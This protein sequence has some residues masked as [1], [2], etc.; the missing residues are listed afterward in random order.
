VLVAE[1]GPPCGW[2]L[3]YIEALASEYHMSLPAIFRLSVTA[4]LALLEARLCRLHPSLDRVSYVERCIIAARNQCR[5]D[6][7][8]RFTLIPNTPL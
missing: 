1:A 8:S 5:R 7:L 6:L 4:G 3:A 2:V